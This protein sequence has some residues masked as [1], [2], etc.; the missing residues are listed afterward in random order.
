MHCYLFFIFSDLQH[1]N[2]C[3]TVTKMAFIKVETEDIKI[4]ETFG[5]KLEETDEDIGWF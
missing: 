1:R 3:D 2:P 4:E 5:V